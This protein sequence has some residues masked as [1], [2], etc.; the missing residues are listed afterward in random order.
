MNEKG[1]GSTLC[2]NTIPCTS[3]GWGGEREGGASLV[4]LQRENQSNWIRSITVP[5]GKSTPFAETV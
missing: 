2:G 1:A 4:F 5:P 3:D